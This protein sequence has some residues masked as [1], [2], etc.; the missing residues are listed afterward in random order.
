MKTIDD[1]YRDE[2]LN[3]VDKRIAWNKDQEE[4]GTNISYHIHQLIGC[5]FWLVKPNPLGY[6]CLYLALILMT[7]RFGE[8]DGAYTSVND[9]GHN[10]GIKHYYGDVLMMTMM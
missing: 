6:Y 1:D 10:H 3:Y 4:V 5:L 9:D 2:L 7:K 8:S